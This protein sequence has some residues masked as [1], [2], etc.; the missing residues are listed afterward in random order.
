MTREGTIKL[1]YHKKFIKFGNSRAIIV[2]MA[3]IKDLERQYDN[4][5]IGTHLDVNSAIIKFTPMWD[6]A[7]NTRV[8]KERNPERRRNG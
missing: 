3:W 2:P 1:R 4:H 5:M 6:S 7:S 8:K